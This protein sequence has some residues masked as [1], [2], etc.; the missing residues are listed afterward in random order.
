MILIDTALRQRE[1]EGR[2]VRVGMFG[3]GAMAKGFVAHVSGQVPGMDVVAIANHKLQE[4]ADAYTFAGRE[5]A[6]AVDNLAA[7]DQA[8]AAGL[9]AIADDPTLLANSAGIDCLI[10]MT[11]AVK[12]GAALALEAIRQGKPLVLMNAEVNATIG[13]ILHERARRAGVLLTCCDGYKPGVEL[14]LWRYVKGLGLTPRV[15][16]NIKGLQDEYLTPTSQEDNTQEADGSEVNFEQAVVANATGFTVSQRGMG[17]RQHCGHIDDLT[18]AYDLEELRELGGIVD[19]VI[20]AR[21]SPGVFCLAEM[22]DP[23]HTLYLALYKL[24]DGPLYSFYQPYHLCYLVA[25]MSL[26]RAVLFGDAVGQ[27]IGAPVVE[28]VAIAKRDLQAGETLDS[29]GQYMTYGQAEK[30]NLV[31]NQGLLPEGLVE[32]CRLL[33][34]I[35]KDQPIHWANVEAPSHEL[36]HQLYSEQQQHFTQPE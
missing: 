4:A 14:N 2:P 29:F 3:A 7:L 5:G 19:F 27:P 9:P 15:L 8:I 21:P 10:D 1:S 18:A 23:R 30:A 25:P 26:A 31:R 36:A 24:G 6:V 17:R 13:P 16:G 20:G 11:G 35:P 22:P 28:V 34:A 32:G 33:R 12:H